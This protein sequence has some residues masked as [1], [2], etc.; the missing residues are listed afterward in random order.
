ML[1]RVSRATGVAATALVRTPT[2]ALAHNMWT[3]ARARELRR[4]S[5][6]Y[7]PAGVGAVFLAGAGPSGGDETRRRVKHDHDERS[8]FSVAQHVRAIVNASARHLFHR[9]R[10]AIHPHN[11]SDSLLSRLF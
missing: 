5:T 6:A 3:H 10:R 1:R 2:L 8:H 9:G 4:E 7:L 11:T